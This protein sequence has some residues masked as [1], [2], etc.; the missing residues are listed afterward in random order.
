MWSG[1]PK[2][3]VTNDPEAVL[4]FWREC[5]GEIVYKTLGGPV[6][7]P[8]EGRIV[9]I[10]TSRVRSGDLVDVERVRHTAC[11]F[12]EYVPKRFELRLTIV[13]RTVY[14]AEVHSRHAE[15]AVDWRLGS[16]STSYKIHNL[17]DDV[18]RKCLLLAQRLGL[19]FAAIDM[20]VTPDDRYVFLEVNANGQW[21]VDRTHTGLPLTA[22]IADLLVA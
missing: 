1:T 3:L 15:A 16:E 20:I 8:E 14:A 19:K 4:Q 2:T 9:S 13:R 17:P 22:A 18:R 6:V 5:E 10:Y 11:L 12:Q 7:D 21:G